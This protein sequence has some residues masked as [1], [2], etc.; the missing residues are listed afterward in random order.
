MNKTSSAVSRTSTPAPLIAG[1]V[2]V[3]AGA[4]AS[5]AVRPD[6]FPTT[7]EF[8][9]DL[10][11]PITGDPMFQFALEYIRAS[12]N[13]DTIDIENVLWALQTLK[14]FYDNVTEPKDI[15]GYALQN[16]LIER[17]FPGHN[18]GHLLRLAPAISEQIGRLIGRINQVVYD[19][20]SYEPTQ[21]ELEEN[22]IDLISSLEGVGTRLD[23]F[24][25]NYDVAIEAALIVIQGEA[26]ARQWRGIRGSVRQTIDL[27]YWG[28]EA[29][30]EYGLLTKLHGSLDWKLQGEHIHV[31]D[32][33][34][35]GDHT[36]Q[37]IIYPGF[38]GASSAPFF[39]AFHDYL[40]Q[41]LA[42]S[43]VLIF[44]GF[45]FRDEH[46]NQLIRENVQANAKVFVINPDKRAR[47]PTRRVRAKYLTSGFDAR[48]VAEV[49]KP[50]IG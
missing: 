9:S 8:F 6:K 28:N 40:S 49:V 34:F 24:T 45:A 1:R 26:T 50:L 32:A 3:F 47:F 46:I 37:A 14:D 27:A 2:L 30:I 7:A 33:V 43:S 39:E 35:T 29:Q 4:G 16:G 44:I 11:P 10:L 20:Y 22:W 13:E 5:K 31:G 15:A 17:L 12:S 23:I 21:A 25:T 48:T 38:K 18:A 36:K 19:L 42:E 41:S